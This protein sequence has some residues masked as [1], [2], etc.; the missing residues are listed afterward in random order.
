ML[1]FA[2]W[3]KGALLPPLMLFPPDYEPVLPLLPFG[4]SHDTIRRNSVFLQPKG[5]INDEGTWSLLWCWLSHCTELG[6]DPAIHPKA[7]VSS[8]CL[9]CALNSKFWNLKA[10]CGILFC[11]NIHVP[12]CHVLPQSFGLEH[13][14]F[15]L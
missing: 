10:K 5:L 7:P 14:I 9:N 1:W 11:L 8:L 15:N 6:K 12:F 4:L 2:R 3:G 13:V